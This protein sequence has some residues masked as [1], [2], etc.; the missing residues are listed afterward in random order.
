MQAIRKTETTDAELLEISVEAAHRGATVIR[1][2]TAQRGAL[3][4]ETKG[5]SDFVSEVDKT[6]EK[7]IAAVFARRLPDAIVMG[8]ELTPTATWNQ[9]VVVIADPLDGTTNFLHGYPEYA[10]SIGV[11]RDGVLRAAVVLNVARDEEFTA[12]KGGGAFLNGKRIRV[13]DLREPGR[14]LIGTGFPFKHIDKLPQYQE[15]FSLVMR[16]TA[17]I[18][19]AGSAALDL[20]NV[21]CGRFDAFWE[22]D[23][24]PWD[25]AAGILM[26][27][28]AGGIV[29]DLDGNPPELRPGGFVAGNPAMHTWLLQTTRRANMSKR[30][31]G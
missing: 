12:T 7:E 18:R 31:T 21:A 20:C 3:V 6:S 1:E 11:A 4:W 29:S 28:E 14:S 17:G 19:R 13:S 10:V 23:L 26:V 25:I 2:A 30:D 9:G 24:S 27:Q 8:E 5:R 22:L 15:Q 16:G